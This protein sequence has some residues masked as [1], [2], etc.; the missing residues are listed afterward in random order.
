MAINT[1][2]DDNG[3]ET[4][5]E[6]MEI[7]NTCIRGTQRTRRSHNCPTLVEMLMMMYGIVSCYAAE[8]QQLDLLFEHIPVISFPDLDNPIS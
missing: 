3:G 6:R 4:K 2:W 8:S 7:F 1:H 5:Q